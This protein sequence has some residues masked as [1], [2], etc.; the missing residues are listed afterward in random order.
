MPVSKARA[1]IGL[2]WLIGAIAFPTICFF[3]GQPRVIKIQPL[4]V[5]TGAD[6]SRRRRGYHL[7]LEGSRAISGEGC[8]SRLVLQQ[9]PPR[10][11][12][13]DSRSFTFSAVWCEGI[14]EAT[15][16][17]LGP[18]H[19]PDPRLDLHRSLPRGRGGG[20]KIEIRIG[21]RIGRRIAQSMEAAA[22]SGSHPKPPVLPEVAR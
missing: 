3:A 6:Q 1:K 14:P 18:D 22:L 21:T 7:V 2:F 4:D 15:E 20:R 16:S 11:C 17:D 8:V 9:E 12:R 19:D 13:G 5:H 10:L